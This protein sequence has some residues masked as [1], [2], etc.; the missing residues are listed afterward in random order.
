MQNEHL[1]EYVLSLKLTDYCC[2]IHCVKT[3]QHTHYTLNRFFLKRRNSALFGN[4][5]LVYLG[6]AW[7]LHL[8][9]VHSMRC[10]MTSEDG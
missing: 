1:L 9:Q 2:I 10:V 4:T 6:V 7:K 3:V 8:T 5:N